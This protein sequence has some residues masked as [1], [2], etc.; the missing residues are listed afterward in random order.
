M[1][2]FDLDVSTVQLSTSLLLKLVQLLV[3][4]IQ[5]C[6]SAALDIVLRSLFTALSLLLQ[7][8]MR[9]M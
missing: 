5:S 4:V 9:H 3:V 6:Q 1:M 2:N 7:V 8:G